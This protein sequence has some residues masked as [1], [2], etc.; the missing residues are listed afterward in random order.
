MNDFDGHSVVRADSYGYPPSIDQSFDSLRTTREM[1]SQAA[2]VGRLLLLQT[3][4]NFLC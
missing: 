1:S 4:P 3:R 2:S